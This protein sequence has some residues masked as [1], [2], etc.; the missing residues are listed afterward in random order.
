MIVSSENSLS[1]E[2]YI[3]VLM[4]LNKIKI[5]IEPERVPRGSV[6]NSSLHN[7]LLRLVISKATIRI[8]SRNF[9]YLPQQIYKL[10]WVNV[11]VVDRMLYLLKRLKLCSIV[12]K[13][14]WLSSGTKFGFQT[15]FQEC[16]RKLWTER[17]QFR[18]SDPAN[19]EAL[20]MAS[21]W[22]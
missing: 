21:K 15:G 10:T 17:L 18:R 22:L 6:R 7:N 4:S 2:W 20:W 11:A 9:H 16:C 3:H 13:A 8:G 1:C 5:N 12:N 19:I 14:I